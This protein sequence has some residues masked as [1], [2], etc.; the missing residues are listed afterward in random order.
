MDI[1]RRG[2]VSQDWKV[3]N[4][5][6]N[7]GYTFSGDFDGNGIADIASAYGS[8]VFMSLSRGNEFYTTE[9]RA[10]CLGR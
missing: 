10:G 7:A 8:T 6:G 1:N 5:W 9:C 4:R 3:A 2:W